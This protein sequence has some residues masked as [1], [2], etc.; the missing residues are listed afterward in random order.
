M[1]VLE[2]AS[3]KTPGTLGGAIKSKGLPGEVSSKRVNNP[4][5]QYL[6]VTGLL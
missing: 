3:H 6:L 1:D 5:Q 4:N 2:H